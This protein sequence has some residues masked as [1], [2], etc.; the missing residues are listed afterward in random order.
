MNDILRANVHIHCSFYQLP[1]ELILNVLDQIDTLDLPA[2]ICAVFTL[3][4]HHNIAP[5]VS[6]DEAAA[7][8]RMPLR[9]CERSDIRSRATGSSLGLHSLPPELVVHINQHLTTGER[10]NFAVATWP[11]VNIERR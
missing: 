11:M 4:R 7:I 3:L 8:R 1:A 2:F 5:N 10:I 9:A 6:A